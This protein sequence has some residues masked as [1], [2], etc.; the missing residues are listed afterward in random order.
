MIM[1]KLKEQQVK[2]KSQTM[3][4]VSVLILT[5]LLF[6]ILAFS[7]TTFFTYKNLYS[8]SY[9]LSIQFFALIGFTMLM[10]MGEIDLSIGSMYAFSGLFAGYL[11]NVGVPLPLAILIAIGVCGVMGAFTGFLVVR[12]KLNSMMVTIA[13]MT[14]IRGIASTVV[15]KLYGVTFSA[16]FRALSKIKIGNVFV[17]IIIM[18]VAVIVLE[19]MLNKSIFFKRMFFVGE[20]EET[21]RIYGIKSDRVKIMA[22]TI[23]AVT[24]AMGGILTASRVTYADTTIGNGLEFHILTAVVLGGASL[25]GGKGSI[26]GSAIGLLFLATILNGMVIFNIDPLLQQLII[27]VILIVSVYIDTKVN[28]E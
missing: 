1:I 21:A 5:C 19:I 11:I 26:L 28:R 8:L 16:D 12:F 13:S 24:A 23:S 7:S 10:I 3:G 20:N 22:F 25:Y 2:R 15:K 18:I 4:A 17:S 9:G 6:M 27:G 14:L